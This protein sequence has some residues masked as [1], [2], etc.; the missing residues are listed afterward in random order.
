MISVVASILMKCVEISFTFVY[1]AISSV[2]LGEIA[3]V[4]GSGKDA[5]FSPPPYN[6]KSVIN[7]I[8]Y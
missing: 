7:L 4:A 5:F 8:L 2:N 3:K 1:R 6:S